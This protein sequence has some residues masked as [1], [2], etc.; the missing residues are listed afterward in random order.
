VKIEKNVPMPT[1]PVGNKLGCSVYLW[2]KMKV[3]D[4]VFYDD[5]P[6][7][8]QSNPSMASKVWAKTNNAKFSARKEG[9][10]VRIWRVA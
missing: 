3:G 6:K 9:N 8:S 4:S 5:Q 7:A 2:N 1:A 10:G